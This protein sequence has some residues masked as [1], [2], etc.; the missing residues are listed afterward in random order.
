MTP[1]ELLARF[2]SD[3]SDA[4][5]PYLWTDADGVAYMKAA[6]TEF[7]RPN[8]GGGIR[9]AS[10]D[11]TRVELAVGEKF[12]EISPLITRVRGARLESTGR[13]LSILNHDDLYPPQGSVSEA[14]LPFHI[15]TINSAGDIC[16]LVTDVE[17]N[18][19]QVVH[20]PAEVDT[21]LLVV[22]RLPQ[23]T[24][25]SPSAGVVTGSLE[26]AAQYHEV[27]LLWMRRMAYMKQDAD[28]F[29]QGKADEYEARFIAACALAADERRLRDHKPRLIRYGGL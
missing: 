16:A 23:N 10:S 27:L 1:T 20:V 14:P 26:V 11:L 5:A 15:S 8:R 25:T 4:E 12:A 7:C 18:A 17:D 29:D 6:Q 9:D 19:V 21:V 28:T 3:M 24:L 2:R 13:P 22:D